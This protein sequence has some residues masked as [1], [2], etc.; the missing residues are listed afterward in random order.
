MTTLLQKISN[1]VQRG[2]VSTRS[3]LDLYTSLEDSPSISLTAWRSNAMPQIAQ[4]KRTLQ[5]LE[6][7]IMHSFFYRV[8][9]QAYITLHPQQLKRAGEIRAR[10]HP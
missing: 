4:I 5:G 6:L 1:E 10:I 8:G 3:A 9:A 7:G 2:Y